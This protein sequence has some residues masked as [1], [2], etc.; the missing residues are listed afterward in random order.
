MDTMKDTE[1]D[2]RTPPADQGIV[3]SLD[4]EFVASA[5]SIGIRSSLEQLGHNGTDCFDRCR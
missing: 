3:P 1:K 4:P 5:E 2:Y